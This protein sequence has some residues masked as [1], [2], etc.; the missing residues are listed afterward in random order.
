M[1]FGRMPK[2]H[3]AN[4]RHV[5]SCCAN[6]RIPQ[7][8]RRG[9]LTSCCAVHLS[10]VIV[11]VCCL[12]TT[13][14]RCCGCCFSKEPPLPR[15]VLAFFGGFAFLSDGATDVTACDAMGECE[16]TECEADC[17]LFVVWRMWRNDPKRSVRH[18]SSVARVPRFW[19]LSR[20]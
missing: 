12:E 2:L 19:R 7:C 18:Y 8:L 11:V 15:P 5:H 9:Q 6:C 1:L 3:F 10:Y 16:Q 20:Y 4:L 14:L 17:M 13:A